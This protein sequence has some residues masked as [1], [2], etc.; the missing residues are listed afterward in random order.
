MNVLIF[1]FF[2]NTSLITDLL[3]SKSDKSTFTNLK[4]LF[5]LVISGI[6]ELS[7]ARPMTDQPCFKYSSQRA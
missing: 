1:L 3:T 2:L 4:L 7:L 6:L 5:F